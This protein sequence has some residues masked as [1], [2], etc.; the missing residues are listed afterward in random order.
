MSEHLVF[1]LCVD[2][3][4][5]VEDDFNDWY[6]HEHLLAVVACPGVISGRRFTLRAVG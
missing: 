3:D 1:A 2:V 4:P 5:A 6:S